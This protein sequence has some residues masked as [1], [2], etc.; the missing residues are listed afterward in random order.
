MRHTLTTCVLTQLEAK[1]QAAEAAAAA[2]AAEAKRMREL[3]QAEADER[4]EAA[5]AAREAKER[6]IKVG[7]DLE[8]IPILRSI[9]TGL[10]PNL[11]GGIQLVAGV[12]LK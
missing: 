3:R 8:V 7:R 5:R 6:A 4:K 9:A 11:S 1:K 10:G 12:N 2:K